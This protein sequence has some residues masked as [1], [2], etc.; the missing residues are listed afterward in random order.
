MVVLPA[1]P[2]TISMAARRVFGAAVVLLKG[3]WAGS[4]A[5]SNGSTTDPPSPRRTMR[6][7]RCF[8]VIN[9]SSPLRK[10]FLAKCHHR[11][12]SCGPKGWNPCGQERRGRQRDGHENKR[13]QVTRTRRVKHR[14]KGSRQHQRPQ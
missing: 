14:L 11:L 4:I 10:L 7:E 1:A 6:R 5:S 9:I 2:C 8:F 3:V 13:G 12:D